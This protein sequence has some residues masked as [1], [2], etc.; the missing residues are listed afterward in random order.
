[1]PVEVIHGP[2]GPARSYRGGR[3]DANGF[4]LKN[5]SCDAVV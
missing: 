3:G 2:R 1:M 5:R 4:L